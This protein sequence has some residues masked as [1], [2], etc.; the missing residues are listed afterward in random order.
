MK[1]KKQQV[2][3]A[4]AAKI[5]KEADDNAKLWKSF[6]ALYF[7]FGAAFVFHI[8]DGKIKKE[9]KME[10]IGSLSIVENLYHYLWT[11]VPGV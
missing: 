8:V 10:D 1:K 3:A 7:I 2:A 6:C 9:K 11:N 4:G 5:E